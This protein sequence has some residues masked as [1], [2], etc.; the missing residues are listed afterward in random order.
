MMIRLTY[1]TRTKLLWII[2]NHASTLLLEPKNGKRRQMKKK[3]EAQIPEYLSVQE[4]E[5]RY[6]PSEWTWRRWAYTGRIGSVKLGSRLLLPVSECERLI[7]AGT[8]PAL[9]S[10]E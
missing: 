7:Q 9:Q 8:R 1:A 5:R 4:A 3:R 10:A 6:G 2:T